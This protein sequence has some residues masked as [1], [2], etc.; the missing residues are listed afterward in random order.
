[1]YEKD[2]AV[3]ECPEDYVKEASEEITDTVKEKNADIST[4]CKNDTELAADTFYEIN[5]K[6]NTSKNN[7][8]EIEK[9]TN[10][11]NE[12]ELEKDTDIVNIK[13]KTIDVEALED[14]QEKILQTP[15]S[16]DLFDIV[17][18]SIIKLL[19]QP[20]TLEEIATQL[21]INKKQAST[22]LERA[23]S[24][25]MVSKLSKPVRYVS[26]QESDK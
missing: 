16:Y 20:M 22:W 1:M 14:T 5:S 12:I 10:T 17:I 15:T 26:K 19:K 2:L 9:N 11:A 3:R 6:K 21:N 4:I 25:N 8:I 13:E 7:D 18:P 23:I 24:L